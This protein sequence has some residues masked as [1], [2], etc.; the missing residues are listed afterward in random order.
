LFLFSF[1]RVAKVTD[2]SLFCVF[3]FASNKVNF[4]FFGKKEHFL[5][6]IMLQ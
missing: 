4:S 3:I 5:S 6:L 2:F 1:Y